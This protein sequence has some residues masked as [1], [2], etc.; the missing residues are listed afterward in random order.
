VPCNVIAK[1]PKKLQ[2]AVADDREVPSM[3]LHI[4][5]LSDSISLVFAS[6]IPTTALIRGSAMAF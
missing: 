5:R 3:L 6:S 1:V 2:Q 4:P